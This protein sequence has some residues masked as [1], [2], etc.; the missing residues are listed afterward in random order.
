M[1]WICFV[2]RQFVQIHAVQFQ[3]LLFV[4]GHTFVEL[5]IRRLHAYVEIFAR[6]LAQQTIYF[7]DDDVI[8]AK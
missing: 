7:M 2:L 6:T 1:N 8:F 5:E 4:E 3:G